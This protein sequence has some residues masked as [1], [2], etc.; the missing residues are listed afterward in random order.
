MQFLK[1]YRKILRKFSLFFSIGACTEP[2]KLS[3]ITEV[4]SKGKLFPA[5]F[6]KIVI[7]IKIYM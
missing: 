6:S 3:V 7:L 2:G 4:M 5:K 1:K